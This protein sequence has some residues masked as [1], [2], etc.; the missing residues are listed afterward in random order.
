MRHDYNHPPGWSSMEDWEK[1]RWMT[2]ERCRRQAERQGLKI[3][4]KDTGEST[5]MEERFNRKLKAKGYVSLSDN[6]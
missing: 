3:Y 2:Q 4:G 1:S 6:R 5:G